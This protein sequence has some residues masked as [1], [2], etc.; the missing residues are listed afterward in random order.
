MVDEKEDIK[1]Y[2]SKAIEGRT[3]LYNN[4]NYW[5]NFFAIIV[6]ALFVAYYT[7]ESKED[8]NPYFA[9]IIG[10]IGFVA[11]SCWLKSLKGFY[12]WMKSW[13]HVVR[14]YEQ[15]LNKQCENL[16]SANYVYSLYMDS[17][18]KKSRLNPFAPTNISTQKVMIR[19]VAVIKISW[20]II[21]C[22]NISSMNLCRITEWGIAL[23]APVITLVLWS[24]LF[25]CMDI[26]S[27][28]K[29][30]YKLCRHDTEG[31]IINK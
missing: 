12:H 13:I 24:C 25:I 5:M 27:N 30:H 8:T 22:F 11:T 19:F 3:L 16:D 28:I 31:Y 18:N 7:V 17:D 6:G 14:H 15:K 1:F 21:I 20:V 9:Q 2:Y 23:L 10:C 4:F 29:G 26:K